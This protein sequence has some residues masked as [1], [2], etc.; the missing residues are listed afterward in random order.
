MVDRAAR[1]AKLRAALDDAAAK[2]ECL[3]IVDAVADDD[4]R[5]MGEACADRKLLTG[6]S[7]IAIGLPANFIKRGLAKGS[8]S[9]FRGAKGP[10][11]I[12]SGSCSKATL[13]QIEVVS[14]RSSDPADRCR[15][16]DG[17]V[18]HGGAAGWLYPRQHRP[19]RR[20]SSRQPRRNA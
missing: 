8:A 15:C 18:R 14:A 12:L 6:G 19:R 17:G 10:G 5:V 2:G 1:A 11:A 16:G 13:G 20:C 3:V 7:G 4:L 9:L